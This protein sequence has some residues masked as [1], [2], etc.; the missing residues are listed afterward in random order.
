MTTT[1]QPS[2]T[3]LPQ[4]DQSL[5]RDRF[6]IVWVLLVAATVVSFWV[7]TEHGFSSDTGRALIVLVIAFVKV[8]YVGLYFMDLRVAPSVLRG[9]FEA[10]CVA[11]CL[12][13][14]AVYLIA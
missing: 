7:G 14:M 9:M 2:E 1:N 3:T 6:T 8:R 10:Y 11:V 5:L 12:A 4:C 13:M